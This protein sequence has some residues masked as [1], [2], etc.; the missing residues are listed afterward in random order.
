VSVEIGM[1]FIAFLLLLQFSLPH[2]EP[3]SC[4]CDPNQLTTCK[5][6]EC[7]RLITMNDHVWSCRER[8]KLSV[9]SNRTRG[10]LELDHIACECD[11]SRWYG[12]IDHTA[13]T[14]PAGSEVQCTP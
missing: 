7:K 4:S 1:K 6:Q 5:V 3:Q 11:T 12:S 9:I 8:G 2:A 13:L 10:R 14:L